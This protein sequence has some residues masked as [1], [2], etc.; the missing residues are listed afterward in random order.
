MRLKAHGSV[1][2]MPSLSTK[3]IGIHQSELCYGADI[4]EALT[5]IKS[6]GGVRQG[7]PGMAIWIHYSNGCSRKKGCPADTKPQPQRDFFSVR[8]LRVTTGI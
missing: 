5:V 1:A 7:S 6:C 4:R 8:Y 3:G 2:T